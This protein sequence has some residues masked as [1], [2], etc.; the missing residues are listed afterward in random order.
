MEDKN[1]AAVQPVFNRITTVESGRILQDMIFVYKDDLFKLYCSQ[2]KQW[3]R[4]KS[5]RDADLFELAEN[6]MR[7]LGFDMEQI[8]I[9]AIKS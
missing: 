6:Y 5:K 2:Y 7:L 4:T 9:M 8:L 3:Q 1:E